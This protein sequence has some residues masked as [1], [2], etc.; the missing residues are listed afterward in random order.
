[1]KEQIET[2]IR[3]EM[4]KGIDLVL[5]GKKKEVEIPRIKPNDIIEYI[6]SLGGENDDDSFNTNGWEW[7]YWFTLKING[8]NYDVSG[9]GYYNDSAYFQLSD[10]QDDE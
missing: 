9:D 8:K 6:E 10:E 4:I 5:S 1:M 2:L 7:D 3:E